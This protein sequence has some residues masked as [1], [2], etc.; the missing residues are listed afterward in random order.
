MKRLLNGIITAVLIFTA[1]FGFVGC[2]EKD[3]G[4]SAPYSNAIGEQAEADD[5]AKGRTHIEIPEGAETIELEDGVFN[6]IR[7]TEDF[8][9]I[10]NDLSANYILANDIVPGECYRNEIIFSTEENEYIYNS[11]KGIF[12]GNNYKFL[13]PPKIPSQAKVPFGRVSGG[14]IRNVIISAARTDYRDPVPLSFIVGVL[15]YGRIEDCINYN[16]SLGNISPARAAICHTALYSEIVGCINYGSLARAIERADSESYH[17]SFMGTAG[18]VEYAADV[19]IVGC[20][21]YGT[22]VGW[23]YRE[24]AV[25]GIVAEA[26][27][28][29]VVE[30]CENYGTIVGE[31]YVGGIT[32]V[33]G[34]ITEMQVSTRAAIE[35]EELNKEQTIKNCNNYGDIYRGHQGIKSK[36]S[37]DYSYNYFFGGIAA[38]ASNVENC[39]NK[40]N[41]LGFKKREGR[42]IAGIAAAA[43]RVENC[44]NE[45]TVTVP[46]GTYIDDIVAYV[47]T[48][49]AEQV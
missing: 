43:I 28:T 41:I 44:V 31:G 9:N 45:G 32:G 17:V 35:Y 25:A 24:D 38:I 46:N 26:D 4:Y 47:I 19:K 42:Y 30:N 27:K 40:G 29:T 36:H 13:P 3:D 34:T 23:P 33:A 16:G 2:G 5:D 12:D 21:N 18:V 39:V 14:T 1:A 10:D 37:E 7:T 6:V 22:I 49:N 48:E 15:E 11:F 8:A 20:K